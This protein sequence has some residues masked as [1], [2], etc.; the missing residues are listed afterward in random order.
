MKNNP[1]PKPLPSKRTYTKE[2]LLQTM[3]K[4]VKTWN[5]CLSNHVI[6]DLSVRALISYCNH[7][8]RDEYAWWA[9]ELDMV[10]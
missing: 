4:D 6:R 8:Y 1:Y 2:S 3:R 10:Y 9:Y 7:V 5:K